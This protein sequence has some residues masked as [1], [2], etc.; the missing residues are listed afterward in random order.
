MA[1]VSQN[2]TES[3]L[4]DLNDLSDL[5]RTEH[6]FYIERQLIRQASPDDLHP[7]PEDEFSDPA[8][9]PSDKI[10]AHYMNL[11]VNWKQCDTKD[12]IEPITVAKLSTGGYRILNGHHRWL[13]ARNLRMKKVPIEIVNVISDDQILKT[14]S[15]LKGEMC[16]SFDLDEVLICDPDKYPAE[17]LAFPLNVA[18]PETIRKNAGLLTAALCDFGFDVWVYTG[19]FYSSQQVK[20]LLGIYR[21]WVSVVINGVNKKFSD[22]PIQESFRNKYRVAVHID[23]ESIIWIDTRKKEYEII[24]IKSDKYWANKAFKLIKKQLGLK[25]ERAEQSTDE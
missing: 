12:L 2:Y 6:A 19:K 10:V 17:K 5:G 8:I 18:F 11:Y 23:N 9:G 20:A 25:S 4:N 13:A 3:V 7:N 22:S 14:L 24:D 15:R 16:V 1:S 21:G